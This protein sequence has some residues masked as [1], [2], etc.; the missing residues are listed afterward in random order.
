[1]SRF[2]FILFQKIS[3]PKESVMGKFGRLKKFVI[4]GQKLLIRAERD[5][6]MTDCQA[7]Y[8]KKRLTTFTQS[9]LCGDRLFISKVARN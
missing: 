7:Y 6:G 8:A 4:Y 1:M 9:A 2:R 5:G 3:M